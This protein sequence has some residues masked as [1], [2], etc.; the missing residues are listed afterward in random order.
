M[1][2]IINP[3]TQLDEILHLCF[4]LDGRTYAMNAEF[5][6]EVTMLPALISPQKLPENTVGILNY[7]GFLINVLDIRSLLNLP[8]KKYT[9][10]NQIIIIKGEESLWAIIVD[11]VSDFISANKSSIQSSSMSTMNNFIK[12]FYRKDEKLVNIL[13]ITALEAFLREKKS[14][15]SQIN[16]SEFFPKDEKSLDILEKRNREIAVKMN[17]DLENNFFG[18]DKYVLFK[19]NGHIYCIYSDFVKELI[20]RKNLTITKI[21]YTPD[22]IKGIINIKGDFFTVLSLKEF[23]GFENSDKKEEEKI[24]VLDSGELKLALLVDEILDVMNIAKDRIQNKNDIKLDNLYIKAEIY[25]ENTIINLLNLEKLLKD[26][27]L[28]FD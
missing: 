15:V 25:N 9:I 18:K 8:S 10:S 26:K 28:C 27:K 13:N 16:Y 22:Y 19:I 12:S 20:S 7:N 23:I 2:Q 14:T 17:F 6:M 21:P 3:L 4:E 5:V 24:I 11:K 1:S